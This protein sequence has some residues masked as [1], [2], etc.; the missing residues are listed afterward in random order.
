M[1][2]YDEQTSNRRREA[3]RPASIAIGDRHG[4]PTFR[5]AH[6]AR[7]QTQNLQSLH[8]YQTRALGTMGFSMISPAYGLGW[9]YGAS[10]TGSSGAAL[11]AW[12]EGPLERCAATIRGLIRLRVA[13]KEAHFCH[14]AEFEPH[15]ALQRD[16]RWPPGRESPDEALDQ[17][18]GL[19]GHST[20]RRLPLGHRQVTSRI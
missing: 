14:N 16:Q 4:P 7:P 15:K 11:L 1:N 12:P 9:R 2:L 8:L 3:Y 20:E 17:L 19:S 13:R 10:P 5:H 6:H 18:S